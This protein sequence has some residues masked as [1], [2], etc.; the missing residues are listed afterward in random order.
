MNKMV[1]PPK[2]VIIGASHSGF[3]CAW[4]LLNGPASYK[5][6][7]FLK[8]DKWETFPEASKYENKDCEICKP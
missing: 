3:S 4:L 7:N 1:K 5:T 2:I 8:L 6:H